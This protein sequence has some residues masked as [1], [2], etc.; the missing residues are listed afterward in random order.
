MNVQ[1]N[2]YVIQTKPSQEE[3]VI[4]YLTQKGI[5]TYFPR[6]QTYIY[7]GLK[8]YKKIKP[9]FPSYVFAQCERKEVCHLCWT[10][11]VKKVLWE[12]TRP[13]PIA[14]ELIYSIESLASKDGLIRPNRFK[15]NDLV[16]I[17]SGPFKD[18]LA[19]F[20]HWESDKQ[21]VCLLLNL[22]NVQIRVSLPASVVAMA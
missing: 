6:T 4:F 7:K 18:I 11:G 13:Q 14:E 5:N 3:K 20:D 2:W 10:R 1:N 21:R 16:M 12:N 22:I 17:K 15:K 9:L 8:R 19:I